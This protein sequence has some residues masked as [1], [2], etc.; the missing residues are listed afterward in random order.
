M[1]TLTSCGLDYRYALDESLH[2]QIEPVL[3]E[4]GTINIIY[5][6]TK[7]I[8]SGEPYTFDVIEYKDV[9]G[10]TVVDDVLLSWNGYRYI[11]YIDEYYS[12]TADN[13]V[14]I[15]NERLGYLYF[16]EDYDYKKDTFVVDGTNAKIV[17]ENTFEIEVNRD[18]FFSPIRCSIASEKYPEIK[19]YVELAYIDDQWYVQFGSSRPCKASDEF[20][21]LLSDNGIISIT[22]P[23]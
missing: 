16:R 13:P 2:E 6:D 18:S 3:E 21:E 10:Y 22:K 9:D 4:D 5:K 15:Y 23:Q 11:W 12:Y 8:Y 19:V 14:Y 7:Y 1:L 20:I 17:F